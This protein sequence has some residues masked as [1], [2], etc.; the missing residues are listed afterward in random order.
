MVVSVASALPAEASGRGRKRVGRPVPTFRADGSPNVQSRSALAI[1]LASGEA[2][3]AKSADAPQPIASLSKLAAA[4][5][6]VESGL[7][8]EATSTIT[9]VDR[10]VA[11]GGA[12]SRLLVGQTYSNDDLLHAALLGSD[13]RAVS[14]LGRS[15][16]LGASALAAAMTRKARDLGLR[17]TRF[18]DPVGLSY[19]NVSTAR[20][21]LGLLRAALAHPLLAAILRKQTHV[22][23]SVT[24]PRGAVPYRNTNQL[25]FRPGVAALGGKTGFNAPAGYCFV[26]AVRT[27]G[28]EIAAAFL[29][30]QGELTRFADFSRLLAWVGEPGGRG[31]RPSGRGEAPSTVTATTVR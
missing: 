15:A 10:I 26:G 3:Y 27:G 18:E 7:R 30:A 17:H 22:A 2:I 23:M 31:A 6:V 24:P 14:A 13:N 16:G 29:G 20:E 8:L 5:V 19:G 9:D 25:L 28:R 1:D 4:L 12:R 11:K 21:V